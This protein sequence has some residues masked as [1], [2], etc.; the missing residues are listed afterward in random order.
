MNKNLLI[1]LGVLLAVAVV[2]FFFLSGKSY[3]APQVVNQT[4][5]TTTTPVDTAG[6]RQINVSAA[7]FAYNP[8]TITVKKGEKV[9]IV[10]KNDGNFPH[11]LTIEDLGLA[12]KTIG[13]GESDTLVFTADKVGSFTFSCT[14]DSHKD[15]GLIGTLVV[16]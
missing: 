13:S 2:G 16:N 15:K 8:S 12:T 14:V 7:E 6:A 9:A 5:T 10:F 3:K 11:N 4:V 1:G